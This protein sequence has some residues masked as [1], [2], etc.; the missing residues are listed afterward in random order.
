MTKG[1]GRSSSLGSI[2]RGGGKFGHSTKP[3]T[4]LFITFQA[5]A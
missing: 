3:L 5:L 1:I 4:K 2:C